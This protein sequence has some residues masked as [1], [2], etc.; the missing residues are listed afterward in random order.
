M[1]S[2][3]T[4]DIAPTS[5]VDYGLYINGQW[6]TASTGM[7]IAVD[8]P[9]TAQPIGSVADATIDD[10]RD[11]VDAAAS[12]GESWAQRAPR[13]RAE[14]LRTAYDIMID[15]SE[16]L[17]T[18]I[19]RENGKS[20]ADAVGEVK[21]AAEF[22]RWYSEEAVRAL[23]SITLSPSGSHRIISQYQPIGVA[24]L[25][26]PWNFP[27]AMATRKIAPA[28]AAGCTTVLKPATDTPL[29]AYAIAGI[30]EE[31][32]VPAGVVNVITTSTSGAVVQSMLDHPA[33][34][35]LSFTGSTEV[36]RILLT[37]AAGNILKTSM[38]LG[39]NAPFIVFEDAWVEDAIDAALIAKMRN[40]GSSCIAANR[41]LVHT[42]VAED[43]VK[44]LADR[45]R[46][47]SI[48]HGLEHSNQLGAMVNSREAARLRALIDAAADEGATVLSAPLPTGLP[49][50][51][52]A[53]TVLTDLTPNSAILTE[54]LFGP[55]APVVTFSDEAEAIALANAT[56]V[57]LA[58]YVY[59]GDLERA[60]RVADRLHT[61]M[62]GV[63]RGV[64]SDPAAPF[65]GV[66]HSGLGRE[67]AHVGLLEFMEEKYVAAS[68]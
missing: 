59:S 66:K 38:E 17:A 27:A 44:R 1:S 58:S 34:R 54:E 16:I 50:T 32:G 15:R 20:W 40:G 63:N 7:T 57:G 48:G 3:V 12:A 8:D 67:G 52:V 18:L 14:I 49:D 37:N 19:V 46:A 53:P 25:I 64:I 22:F 13:E 36:G 26:T 23:G 68:W 55:V 43:F 2:G 41:F 28:L 24:V 42:S 61:G 4:T 62:V 45:M 6:R 39:G 60:L 30:L 33:V 5:K 47:M 51:F 35:K 21:Y 11:A 9:A 31:A 10:A 29:T 56:D 65:G